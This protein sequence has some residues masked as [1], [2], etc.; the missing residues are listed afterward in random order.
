M[1][2]KFQNPLTEPC[3]SLTP[4]IPYILLSLVER[5]SCHALYVYHSLNSETRKF[6]FLFYSYKWYTLLE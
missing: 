5:K 1:S 4:A 3:V 2:E 6:T